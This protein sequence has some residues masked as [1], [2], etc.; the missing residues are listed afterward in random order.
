[1]VS[2]CMYRPPLSPVIYN[3]QI[4]NAIEQISDIEANQFLICG[5]FNYRDIDWKNHYIPDSA[6][7][8]RNFYDSVQSAFLHQHV[9]DIT[10]QR[11]SNQPS[12]LDLILSKNELEIQ[13]I[14][15]RTPVAKSDHNVLTFDFLL[16]G[17]F[18]PLI[19]ILDR[20]LKVQKCA[21][22]QIL[23]RQPS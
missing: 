12:T 22:F 9:E 17:R 23:C 15:I 1:M 2:A 6:H 19:Y 5:N 13:K 10:R 16:E 14:N 4:A 20:A 8:E 21:Q 3:Q 7:D 11:G 18:Q